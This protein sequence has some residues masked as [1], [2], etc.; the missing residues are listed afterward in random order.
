MTTL[1]IQE[2][3]LNAKRNTECLL[4]DFDGV[5]AETDSIR[6]KLLSEIFESKGIDSTKINSQDI[7]GLSTATYLKKIYPNLSETLILNIISQRQKLFFNNLNTYLK[8]FPNVEEI[9]KQLANKYD[10][11]LATTNTY[12]NASAMLNFLG[13]LD[14]FS[15]I[16]GRETIENKN[17]IK[18][19][20][21]IINKIGH[22]IENTIVV[23]D[24]VVGVNAAKEAG[25]F[26]I[27]FNP[28][29]SEFINDKSDV[30]VNSFIELKSFI[31]GL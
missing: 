14:S 4:I 22:K 29:K 12:S 5:I 28:N 10:L 31:D 16:Y 19:Y 25:F 7:I 18:D 20:S 27:R 21:L 1:K 23:E 11:Q 30:V 26:C 17:G 3:I 24:S 15:Q 9:I 13:I 6:I 8:P 2:M